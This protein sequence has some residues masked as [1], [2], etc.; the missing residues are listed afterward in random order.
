MPQA[1]YAARGGTFDPI[2]SSCLLSLAAWGNNVIAGWEPLLPPLLTRSKATFHTPRNP[3]PTG[4]LS[5]TE[6]HRLNRL[7]HHL[8]TASQ[9]DKQKPASAIGGFAG[10]CSY[11]DRRGKNAVWILRNQE[12]IADWLSAKSSARDLLRETSRTP[13]ADCSIAIFCEQTPHSQ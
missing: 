9:Q 13:S 11:D 12:A 2:R 4:P 6:K 8:G 1:G 10:F 3:R 5:V 7:A